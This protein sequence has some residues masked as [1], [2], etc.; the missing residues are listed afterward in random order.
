MEPNPDYVV[1]AIASLGGV[2]RRLNDAATGVVPFT[3]WKQA[4]GQL[5]MR[6]IV[7]LFVGYVCAWIAEVCGASVKSRYISGAL[8]GWS[9]GELMSLMEIIYRKRIK[10]MFSKGDK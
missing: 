2:A 6:M 4:I 8:G 10:A 7:A 3:G 5:F 9:G 1:P